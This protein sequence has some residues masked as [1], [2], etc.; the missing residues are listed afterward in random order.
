MPSN[1]RDLLHKIFPTSHR[2]LLEKMLKRQ[3]PLVSGSVL[4]IGAGHD[5]YAGLLTSAAQVCRTDVSSEYE[6]DI[7]ADAHD[8][9]FEAES[10]DSVVAIE[11]FEHLSKPE[12]AAREVHRV[13]KPGGV[14]Y[15]SVP[16]LFHVHG[17]PFD[18]TRFTQ[19][20]LEVLFESF[21][22][23]EVSGFGNRFHV[24]SD[25]VTTAAGPWKLLRLFNHVIAHAIPGRSMDSPS[26]YWI[27]VTR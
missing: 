6:V 23:C 7:V 12:V 5:P 8:L 17:D 21:R 26:G 16:F 1:P 25:L 19:T 9:P 15:I 4:I 3:L 14:A 20:G 10:F 24:I 2:L 22:K 18:F 11:V 13:L 27:Q